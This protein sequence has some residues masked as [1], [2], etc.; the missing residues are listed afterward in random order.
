MIIDIQA[1][2]SFQRRQEEQT[3]ERITTLEQGL[4]DGLSNNCLLGELALKQV[5]NDPSQ[6]GTTR[7]INTRR[8]LDTLLTG[9]EVE[10]PNFDFASESFLALYGPVK[11]R[12]RD[13]SK[14]L[15]DAIDQRAM[16]ATAEPVRIE[17]VVQPQKQQRSWVPQVLGVA[18]LVTIGGMI[19]NALGA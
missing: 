13:L 6:A 3:V 7:L 19:L 5:E 17:V 4:I 9:I 12:M 16:A 11:Q 10:E 8:A 15:A 18:I 14:A 2:P 1:H